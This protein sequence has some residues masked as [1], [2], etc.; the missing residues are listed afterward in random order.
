MSQCNTF[1]Y[2]VTLTWIHL[3][4]SLAVVLSLSH[5]SC[6]QVITG[7][8]H[9]RS[10]SQVYRCFRIILLPFERGIAEVC[11]TRESMESSNF[12]ITNINAI[13]LLSLPDH[14]LVTAEQL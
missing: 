2:E 7:P 10:H 4:Y 9:G 11:L 8:Q 5:I 6:C 12:E 1:Y 3:S 13:L 14:L